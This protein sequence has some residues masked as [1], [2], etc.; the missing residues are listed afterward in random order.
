MSLLRR[1]EKSASVKSERAKEKKNYRTEK[2]LTCFSVSIGVVKD[3]CGQLD[4][5]AGAAKVRHNN[6]KAL[7][8]SEIKEIQ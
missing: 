2:L 7:E 3:T 4:S 1:A 6:L 8:H 5:V